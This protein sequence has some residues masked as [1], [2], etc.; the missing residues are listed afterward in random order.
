MSFYTH[1]KIDYLVYDTPCVAQN[2][3]PTVL[4]KERHIVVILSEEDPIVVIFLV[5]LSPPPIV[6]ICHVICR[7]APQ[8]FS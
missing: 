1:C 6:V 5:I 4:R 2:Q 3:S 8:L 7:L